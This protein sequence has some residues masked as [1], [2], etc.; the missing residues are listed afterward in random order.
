MTQLHLII[1]IF[2]TAAAIGSFSLFCY[3]NNTFKN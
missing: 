2:S 3:F 1:L